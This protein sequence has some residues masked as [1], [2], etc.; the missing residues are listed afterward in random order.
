MREDDHGH[1]IF[2]FREAAPLYGLGG[3]PPELP[4]MV[5]LV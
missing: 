1:L 3:E 4:H 2:G 5:S